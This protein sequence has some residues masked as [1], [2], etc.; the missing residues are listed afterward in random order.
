MTSA[1]TPPPGVAAGGG[2]AALLE[3]FRTLHPKVMDLSLER[4]EALLHKLGDPQEKLPPVIHVAGTNGKGSV[5]AFLRA[6]LEAAGRR[7]HTF[8][9]PHLIRFHE[10]IGLAGPRGT[11]PIDEATLAA[12]L[13]R[14]ERANAG[15]AITYFEITTAAAFLAYAEHPAD[16]LLLETGLGGR[17][18]ATNVLAAPAMSVITP[19][20]M[21]HMSWL[22]DSLAEIA[23]EKAG[24]IKRG[25]PVVCAPQ[26]PAAFDV[27]A[28]RA[29]ELDSPLIAHGRQWDVY[30]QAGRLVYQDEAGLLDLP[31][32][33]LHGRFQHDNA[34]TALAAL[35][36]LPG[37]EFDEGE[38]AAGLT[39]AVWPGRMQL[40]GHGPLAEMAGEDAEL[41]LDGGHNAAAGACLAAT[42]AEMADRAAKPVVLVCAMLARKQ[43][44]AFFAPFAGLVQ[45]V[46]TLPVPGSENGYTP[47]E[48]AQLAGE[49]G[50]A[51]IPSASLDAALRLSGQRV[52]GA[53]RVLI[54]G[55][56]YLAGHVLQRNKNEL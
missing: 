28:T 17:L 8:T 1:W 42:L 56:L 9:S 47:E 43:A 46:I 21:D 12:V 22:G 37:F 26:A 35:R 32:P 13:A 40:L 48:L 16:I 25:R 55:S 36:H 53:R 5:I 7:V 34:G 38:L 11:Q 4:I 31:L 10:R 29:A 44:Q 52:P 39:H 2:S 15:A 45:Q 33:R 41:W 27:L 23:F 14:C 6:M 3:H 50:L 49:A 54:T 51:A 24:I 18:D 20:S 19:I 30:A